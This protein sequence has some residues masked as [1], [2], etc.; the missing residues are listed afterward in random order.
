MFTDRQTN[1]KTKN[2]SEALTKCARNV[3]ECVGVCGVWVGVCVYVCVGVC[4]CVCVCM[5][6]VWMCV[7]VC[8]CIM[9]YF[10]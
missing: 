4:M 2:Y 6:G 8:V 3:T 7:C 5:C 10:F 1:L 9:L